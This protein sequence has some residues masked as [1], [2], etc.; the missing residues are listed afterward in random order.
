VI[1]LFATALT[2]Q[3]P[4]KILSCA[5][6]PFGPQKIEIR[7]LFKPRLKEKVTQQVVIARIP[8]V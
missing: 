8:I 5:I 3:I 2:V 7:S 6:K 1:H 4:T